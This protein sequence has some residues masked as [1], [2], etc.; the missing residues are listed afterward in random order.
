MP[1]VRLSLGSATVSV[2]AAVARAAVHTENRHHVHSI[3]LKLAFNGIV[4]L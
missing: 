2:S 3:D 1:A 4:I